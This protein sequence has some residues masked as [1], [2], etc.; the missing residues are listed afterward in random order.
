MSKIFSFGETVPEY[1][2]KV[3]NEREVRASAGILFF[4]AMIAFMNSWLIGDF[5]I[6]KVFVVMFMVD[7]SIRILINPKYAPTLILGRFFVRHQEVEYVGAPQKRVAWLIGL[8]L[9]I[10]MFYLIVLNNLMGPGNL[11][12]CVICLTLLFFEAAFGI[13][14]GCKLYNLFNKEKA[15]LCPGNVCEVRDR[16]EIQKFNIVQLLLVPLFIG[17]IVIVAQSSLA[18][19]KKFGNKAAAVSS[20]ETTEK[21]CEAPDWAVAMG[22]RE[23]WKLHNG[24]GGTATGKSETPVA[25][26]APVAVK[27]EVEATTAEKECEAPDWAVKMGHKEKWKLHNGCGSTDTEKSETPVAKPAPVA[28][29]KEVEATTA[30]KDCE[31]PDWAVKMGHK[32][33]WKLHN[34]CGGISTEK[35]EVL[36]AKPAPVVVKKEV[37]AT[38]AEKECEAPDWAIKMGHEDKWKLHNGC[39]S[40][41][42]E[43]SET[44]VAKPVPA[45]PVVKVEPEVKAVDKECEVPDWAIKMGHREKWKLHNGRK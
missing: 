7:F 45:P 8:V 14:L 33:K 6:T 11:L 35:T 26:S 18:E 30:E 44:V 43:K 9:S 40:T 39:G 27:K 32:E 3:L 23:K 21:E 2:M 17:L 29:K 16:V 24:C 31:A 13:C 25:K 28:V 12:V 4:F 15:K 22:H 34:G 37:E 38:T 42:T 20:T 5:T 1:E 36:V 41:A 19:P 10:V